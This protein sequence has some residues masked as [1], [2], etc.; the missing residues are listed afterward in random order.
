MCPNGQ[1]PTRH[2][3]MR[4]DAS[5]PLGQRNRGVRASARKRSVASLP[6]ASTGNFQ[7]RK[8]D[9]THWIPAAVL[10]DVLNARY[11]TRPERSIYTLANLTSVSARTIEAWQDGSTQLVRFAV[12]D[13]VLTRSGLLDAWHTSPA[14]RRFYYSEDAA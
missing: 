11:F 6:P 14:L 10:I 3:A 7:R 4:D 9:L 1:A 5:L 13:R 2:Y 8:G 12:A